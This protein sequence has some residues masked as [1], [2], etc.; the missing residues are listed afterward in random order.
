MRELTFNELDSVS[1]GDRKT[2]VEIS[3]WVGK[4][5]GGAIGLK[6]G[7]PVGML[8]GSDIG[9][10]AAGAAAGWAWDTLHGWGL[11]HD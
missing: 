9:T 7:G 5:G 4:L 6:L 11:V 10:D 3:R 2:T 1:G 8:A